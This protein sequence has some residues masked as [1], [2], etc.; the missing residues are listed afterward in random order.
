M[1]SNPPPATSGAAS[2]GSSGRGGGGGGGRGGGGNS[3][4]KNRAN[5]GK[6]P[7]D[8]ANKKSNAGKSGQAA[9]AS[10]SATTA[11]PGASNSNAAAEKKKRNNRRRKKNNDNKKPGQEGGGG[12]GGNNNNNSKNKSKPS[13]QEKQQQ[14]PKPK[15]KEPTEEEL[16]IL[17]EQKAE[18]ERQAAIKKAAEDRA[19]AI[20]KREGEIQALEATFR[21]KVSHLTA[22]VDKTLQ[23]RKLRADLAPEELSKK[24][25]SF[26]SSKSKLKS[27]LKKC[28]AF[29]KKIK[30][31]N[32]FDDNVV[33]SFLKDADTLNLTRYL[34]EIA[35]AFLESKLKVADVQGVAKV[36][37][38]LHERYRDFMVDILLPSL[39][40]S[41][42]GKTAG[43]VTDA[44]QK[45]I[46]LRILT[47][48]LI[49]GVLP[50]TK[51][52]MKIVA[53]AAGAPK[54]DGTV[55][56]EKYVVN[57]PNMLVSFAK[58]AGHELIGVIPKS[59]LEDV[60][61]ILE[62]EKRLINA[63]ANNEKVQSTPCTKDEDAEQKESDGGEE[64]NVQNPPD[65]LDMPVVVSPAIVAD[66]KD[67]IQRLEM[68]RNDRAVSDEVCDRFKKHLTGAF[69]YLCV[70]LVATHKKLVKMEKRCEQDRLLAGSISEE[71]ERALTDARKLLESLRKSVEALSEVLNDTMPEL[72]AEEDE[73][74][75]DVQTGLELYK[76]E[77]GRDS[78]LGPFDDEE[79]R[80]FYCDIPDLLTTIPPT[81]LGYSPEDVEK[82]QEAN[83]KK[84]GDNSDE[85]GDKDEL[86][87]VD[88]NEAQERDFEEDDEENYANKDAGKNKTE[89]T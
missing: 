81:L 22:F 66:A 14:K 5:K 76:G 51:P 3:R 42:K 45:R 46:F 29:C 12:G 33:K 73:K 67:S 88:E 71:R 53:D 6:K 64:K 80:A 9:S 41:L 50:E 58:A 55:V 77:D 28:T 17:A 75:A 31:T 23:R 35:N 68:V 70:T 19:K 61:F 54:G 79:T 85:D 65:E 34:E 84:Y 43:E 37:I 48:L 36:C 89:G 1:S 62:E 38:A 60:E 78:N 11:N 83:S 59:I 21:E 16:H 69:Q 2:G 40:R 39:L 49:C 26:Q 13:K 24:Q 57:D 52:V 82:I 20:A 44:K 56:G 10:A 30:S 47:E 74:K 25:A 27:D 32:S 86:S 15:P 72:V 8:D 87:A 7:N 63:K 4:R 18:A